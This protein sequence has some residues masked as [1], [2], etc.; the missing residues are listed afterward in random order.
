MPFY[1]SDFFS[2][3]LLPVLIFMARVLDVSFGTIRIIFVTRGHK[4]LAPLI[5]FFELL[6]WLVAIG[7]VVQNLDNVFCY[8]AYAG[9][10]AAG[11]YLGICIEQRLAMGA[12]II[13]II[14]K[15]D[16]SELIKNLRAEGYGVTSIPAYGSSGQVSVVY[17][18]VRRRALKD[19]VA[20]VKRFNPKA[21]YSIEDV[22]FVSGAVFPQETFIGRKTRRGLFGL[23]RKGK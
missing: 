10:F 22:R 4:L 8:V 12:V 23:I 19:V 14:T 13:R 16:A 3:I 11:N 1:H 7:K 2:F 20:I 18:V 17:S 21:F 15:E 6:I 5:G 9:G